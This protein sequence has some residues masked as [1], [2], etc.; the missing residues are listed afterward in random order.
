M[1][2]S[3]VGRGRG[4]G[5]KGRPLLRLQ[6]P[7]LWLRLALTL[8]LFPEPR[9]VTGKQPIV[10]GTHRPLGSGHPAATRGGHHLECRTPLMLAPLL[11]IS[12]RLGLRHR[13]HRP[14]SPGRISLGR[15][16]PGGGRGWR[17]CPRCH[18][19][20]A[21]PRGLGRNKAAKSGYAPRLGP[22]RTLGT[23]NCFHA[24]PWL[25]PLGCPACGLT[26]VLR[27]WSQREVVCGGEDSANRLL[28]AA[29]QP[30]DWSRRG[31]GKRM[32][33]RAGERR[34]WQ[35]TM[36]LSRPGKGRAPV[37]RPKMARA[38]Y[39]ATTRGMSS[40]LP[41][42]GTQVPK[43]TWDRTDPRGRPGSPRP[44]AKSSIR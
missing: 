27:V 41:T 34:R 14:Q 20:K 5:A 30:K 10:V 37:A 18:G 9:D 31:L 1:G 26:A 42:R 23:P 16:P 25:Q 2:D 6:L 35:K 7:A 13:G 11:G 12:G 4:R 32:R 36:S 8:S 43:V 22:N 24:S 17:G 33:E 21:P 3:A 38:S 28:L 19:D 15:C 44:P 29:G 39:P 40:P